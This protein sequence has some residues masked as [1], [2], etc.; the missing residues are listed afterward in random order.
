MQTAIDAINKK[1]QLFSAQ[2]SNYSAIITALGNMKAGVES[3][4][5]DMRAM[6]IVD[7]ID[8]AVESFAKVRC[9]ISPLS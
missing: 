3:G 4:D 6:N 5:F 8:S 1:A 2:A 7:G 9:Y